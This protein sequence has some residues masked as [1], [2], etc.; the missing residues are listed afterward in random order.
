M[1]TVTPKPALHGTHPVPSC[2]HHSS[3]ASGTWLPRAAGWTL[4][5]E[6]RVSVVGDHG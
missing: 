5:A 6:R 1:G 2:T 3:K 4:W